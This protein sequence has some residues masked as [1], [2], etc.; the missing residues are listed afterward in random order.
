MKLPKED[1]VIILGN[2]HPMWLARILK[3]V[4]EEA[5]YEVDFFVGW[6]TNPDF[7]KGP[8]PSFFGEDVFDSYNWSVVDSSIWIEALVTG[9]WDEDEYRAE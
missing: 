6:R 8:L 7:F 9:Y 3:R 1:D 2:E 5:S 4:P